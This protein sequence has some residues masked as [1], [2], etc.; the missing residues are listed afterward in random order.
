MRD[1]IRFKNE[2]SVNPLTKHCRRESLTCPAPESVI[3]MK[4]LYN[5]VNG[6]TVMDRC[7]SD[8]YI[9]WCSSGINPEI[10]SKLKKGLFPIQ[11]Y[12][13]LH[14]LTIEDSKRYVEEFIWK[15]YIEKL[16]SVLIVH[17]RG[18]NSKNKNAKIKYQLVHW[19][20]SGKLK[21]IVRAFVSARNIDGGLGAAYVLLE[22]SRKYIHGKKN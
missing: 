11:A 9:E 1:V 19:L 5:I 8:E 13:D 15:K 3:A 14:Y 17:G 10:F 4:K 20:R 18:N 21:K 7:Y 22:P 6:R 12:I 16:Q 2:N